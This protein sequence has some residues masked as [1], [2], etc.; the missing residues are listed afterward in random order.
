MKRT[1]PDYQRRDRGSKPSS[2]QASRTSCCHSRDLKYF[3]E[4]PYQFKLRILY[5]FN[6]P[7]HEALGYGKSLHDALAEVHTRAMEGDFLKEEEIAALVERHLHV[8]FAYESLREKLQASAKGVLSRYLADN[9]D[10]LELIEYAEKPIEID[11]GDGVTVVGRIDLVRRKDTGKTSIV[12]FKSNERAQEE[13]VTETAAPRLRSGP[14]GADRRD[15]R[16]RGDLRAR[17]GQTDPAL[18][19]G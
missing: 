8:P 4:C 6:A 12:D 2:E 11:L 16:L 17:G 9:A 5:G 3:F 19:A 10:D 14:P 15:R 13:E 1:R 18:G 7:I